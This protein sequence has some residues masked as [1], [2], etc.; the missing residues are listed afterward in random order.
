MW[1]FCCHIGCVLLLY[2]WYQCGNIRGMVLVIF[3][4]LVLYLSYFCAYEQMIMLRTATCPETLF[5]LASPEQSE[6][7][8]ECT[9]LIHTLGVNLTSSVSED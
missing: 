2:L 1:Y 8:A 5:R 6:I 7:V 4:V 3:V 9:M